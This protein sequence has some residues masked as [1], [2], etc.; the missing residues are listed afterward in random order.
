MS[1]PKLMNSIF[2]LCDPLDELDAE[3]VQLQKAGSHI[4]AFLK[5]PHNLKIVRDMVLL[6]YTVP[7]K[8][9]IL[10]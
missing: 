10:F 1:A 3:E 6:R 7:V 2:Q 9:P 5:D 4:A 8:Q